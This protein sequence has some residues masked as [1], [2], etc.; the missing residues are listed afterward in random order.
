MNINSLTVQRQ[1]L[2]DIIEM[3]STNM[4]NRQFTLL[5]KFHVGGCQKI[6]YRTYYNDKS[7]IFVALTLNKDNCPVEGI[8]DINT[9]K[10]SKKSINGTYRI[11]FF[12]LGSLNGKQTC[13]ANLFFLSRKGIKRKITDIS[14]IDSNIPQSIHDLDGLL[15]IFEEK[16][17]SL[18][19]RT[20]IPE[21]FKVSTIYSQ[22]ELLNG[23]KLNLKDGEIAII[24]DV[25][26]SLTTPNMMLE[27]HGL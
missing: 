3:I 20:Y 4:N 8:F 1:D 23:E 11:E 14:L 21:L 5:K 22:I 13:I 24:N 15:N 17:C 6:V 2:Y 16:I 19:H 25:I 27:T 10:R 9:H 7:S 26:G 18:S 12:A